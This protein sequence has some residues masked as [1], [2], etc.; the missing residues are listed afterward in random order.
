MI[1]KRKLV[2]GGYLLYLFLVLIGNIAIF[3]FLFYI[4]VGD[5][6][7]ELFSVFKE[8]WD[9]DLPTGL[10]ERIGLLFILFYTM[11]LDFMGMEG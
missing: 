4:T 3:S 11:R 8:K 5:G 6:W 2:F 9:F 1:D 10:L 7:Q